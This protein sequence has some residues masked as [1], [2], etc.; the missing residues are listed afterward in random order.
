MNKRQ[1]KKS[2][3]NKVKV[4]V[5][6]ASTDKKNE[7]KTASKSETKVTKKEKCTIKCITKKLVGEFITTKEEV[8][9]SG[10]ELINAGAYAQNGEVVFFANVSGKKEN[11]VVANKEYDAIV[12]FTDEVN[13]WVS[14]NAAKTY[15]KKDLVDAIYTAVNTMIEEYNK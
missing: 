11:A 10:S 15:T 14:K 1:L 4:N 12:Y 3:N 2:L 7:K 5:A 6:L 13:G 8:V 9:P